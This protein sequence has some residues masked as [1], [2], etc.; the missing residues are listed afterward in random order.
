MVRWRAAARGTAREDAAHL[1][2]G[3]HAHP[4]R[5]RRAACG[6]QWTSVDRAL[7]NPRLVTPAKLAP[8]LWRARGTHSIP[9]LDP[10]RGPRRLTWRGRA[11]LDR[12]PACHQWITGG[13]GDSARHLELQRAAVRA[14]AGGALLLCDAC[15]LEDHADDRSPS[16]WDTRAREWLEAR[17]GPR[18]YRQLP[19]GL[20]VPLR[21]RAAARGLPRQPDGARA[22]AHLPRS[23]Q[24]E[25]HVP[26]IRA[27]ART[28]ARRLLLRLSG[29][30]C[31]VR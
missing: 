4:I 6:A 20:P 1:I 8:G 27:R 12:S 9:G 2:L 30:Q 19:C 22:A 18:E 21:R 11:P 28:S 25:R 13:R 3:P 16:R 26:T 14:R 29:G 17:L 5:R 24:L 15:R 31:H 7:S 10:R 23:G